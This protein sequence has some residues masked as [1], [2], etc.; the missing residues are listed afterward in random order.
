MSDPLDNIG[1]LTPEA[2]AV[3]RADVAALEAAGRHYAGRYDILSLLA[4][5][6]AE[7]HDVGMLARNLA[8]IY[9]DISGGRVSKPNTDAEVVIGL[10]YERLNREVEAAIAED[11]LTRSA[12]DPGELDVERL[13]RAL[14]ACSWPTVAQPRY[15]DAIAREYAA[16]RSTP[17][18]PREW[19][20]YIDGAEAFPEDAALRS[21]PAAPKPDTALTVERLAAAL[22]AVA[23]DD[24]GAQAVDGDESGVVVAIDLNGA[25]DE[26]A[27]KILGALKYAG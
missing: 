24:E 5:L 23:M 6:D 7:R 12:A 20:H 16:A 15:A 2:E 13:R 4:S 19:R 18:A 3:L 17:A 9:D 27:R 10:F 14:L 21:T 25:Q 8:V 22:V 26:L 11:R 1:P